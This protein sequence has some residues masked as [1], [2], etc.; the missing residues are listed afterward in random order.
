MIMNLYRLYDR[1]QAML[2][3]KAYLS[4]YKL[5]K[6][7]IVL[8]LGAFFGSFSIIAAKKVGPSGRVISYEPDRR[9]FEIMK[10]NVQESG[11]KNITLINKAVFS[12]KAV[13]NIS[14][15]F[16]DSNVFE[17]DLSK[18]SKVE[19]DTIDN[20]IKRL[21]LKKVDFVKM[22]VEG[23]E[24]EIMEGAKSSI[25]AVK[26]WAIA[27]Y[28][29]RDGKRTGE[30]LKPLFEKNGFRVSIGFPIHET[31]CASKK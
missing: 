9:N 25:K 8:D 20:E 10:K 12:K 21:K 5:K 7:D 26:N 19:A 3:S 24:L 30:I 16:A 1:I 14:S 31:L 23:A 13:L 28:H 22:D 6:G 15:S 18:T 2:L 11:L 17:K 27:C 29:K 4:K